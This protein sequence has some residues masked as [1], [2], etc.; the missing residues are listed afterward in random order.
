LISAGYT[1]SMN[2][3]FLFINSSKRS[4]T[5]I[6]VYMD[7]IIL[8]GNDKKEIDRIKQAFNKTFKI[9]DLGDLRCFLGLEVE[10]SKNG[11]MMNQRNYSLELLKDAG[12]L[13]CKLA[14]T[15][16]DNLIKLSTTGSVHFIEFMLKERW[17]EGL[18]ISL[19][20]DLT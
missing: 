16:I 17:L 9:K 13:A 4:F 1:Q 7:G 10:R 8:V 6:L 14:V 2:D 12:L 18:C 20:H 19:I 5:T 3:H 11:I 15:P